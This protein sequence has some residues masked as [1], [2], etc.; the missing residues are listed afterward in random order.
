LKRKPKESV[1]KK[2]VKCLVPFC[3]KVPYASLG[4]VI[5]S[6]LYYGS[7]FV[8]RYIGKLE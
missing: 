1:F 4:A 5:L 8:M 2:V 6:I 7:I 3:K